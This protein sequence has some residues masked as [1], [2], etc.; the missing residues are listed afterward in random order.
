MTE[1]QREEAGRKHWLKGLVAAGRTFA[2]IMGTPGLGLV[3]GLSCGAW[4]ASQTPRTSGADDFLI[5]IAW[6]VC[7][8]LYGVV[9]FVGGLAAGLLG[10]VLTWI[11]RLAKRIVRSREEQ[12]S[13]RA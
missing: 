11:V 12:R 6:L 5:S 4:V 8:A 7:P 10:L 2:V 13:T 3:G 9:G 1:I